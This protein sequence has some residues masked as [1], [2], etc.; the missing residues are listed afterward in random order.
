MQ[1][2]QNKLTRYARAN[3]KSPTDA[4]QRLWYHLREIPFRQYKF[5]RQ[6]PITGYIVDFVSQSQQLVIE[7]DGSQHQSPEHSRY[8]CQRAYDLSILGYRTLRFWNHDVLTNTDA[9]LST[10]LHALS[11]GCG[12]GSPI[13]V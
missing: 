12:A 10:I 9:V 7:L 13:R 6:Q 5:R 4:E 2:R 1:K 11:P 3:R 8:D